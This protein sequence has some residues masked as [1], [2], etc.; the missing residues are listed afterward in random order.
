MQYS[1]IYAMF[2][3]LKTT[4][5][6]NLRN[7]SFIES[8]TSFQTVNL[9]FCASLITQYNIIIEIVLNGVFILEGGWV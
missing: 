7:V 3:L 2:S 4:D 9:G 8:T 5:Y 6:H 1:Y